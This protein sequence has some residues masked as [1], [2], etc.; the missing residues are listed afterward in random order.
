MD[1]LGFSKDEET[2]N[3][4]QNAK[5]KDDT[6]SNPQR[7]D[8]G[9]SELKDS[10]DGS[11]SVVYGASSTKEKVEE[12]VHITMADTD[13]DV[14]ADRAHPNNPRITISE[15]VNSPCGSDSSQKRAQE[16]KAPGRCPIYYG[17]KSY[18]HDFYYPPDKEVLKSGEFTQEDDFQF[19]VEPGR[20][21][22]RGCWF[23]A[24]IWVGVNLMLLG[25][26]AM[27]VGHLTPARETI[28]SQHE[29][30][31]ILDRWAV[32]YNN[33]LV[34]CQLAGLAS[35]TCGSIIVMLVLLISSYQQEQTRAYYVMAATVVPETFV[36]NP[37]V[38]PKKGWAIHRIPL[39]GSVRG[40]QPTLVR[41]N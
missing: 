19:L 17:I 31:T 40:V 10:E 39:S 41:T 37:R 32:T 12:E 27:L 11:S 5:S 15:A 22:W 23:R 1:N 29:N 16:T 21:R 14:E 9:T 3:H 20:R 7:Q 34:I 28:V 26:I 6:R 24:G 13:D 38:G 33:R 36:G 4:E 35:F 25:I 30:Y 8:S 2:D 18:L